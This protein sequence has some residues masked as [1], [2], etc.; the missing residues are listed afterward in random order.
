MYSTCL[1]GLTLTLYLAELSA[2][3]LSLLS[4][5]SMAF[6]YMFLAVRLAFISARRGCQICS[7]LPSTRRGCLQGTLSY[8]LSVAWLIG[9]YAACHGCETATWFG[10]L[11]ATTHD[12][13]QAILPFCLA[14]AWFTTLHTFCCLHGWHFFSAVA[15]CRLTD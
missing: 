4:T 10:C 11:P 14:A 7:F 12:C 8:C 9:L 2:G 1:L 6:Q 5:C 3:F 13:L 15:V